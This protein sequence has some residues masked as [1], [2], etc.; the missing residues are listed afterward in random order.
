MQARRVFGDAAVLPNGVCAG[1]HRIEQRQRQRHA[2]PAQHGAPGNVLLGDDHHGLLSH[3]SVH[4]VV[5]HDVWSAPLAPVLRRA[6][7]GTPGSSR[8]P[9]RMRKNDCRC[10]RRIARRWRAPPACRDNPITRPSPYASSF[11]VNVP[12]NASEWFNNGLAQAGRTVEL[13]AVK[14]LARGIDPEAA[15]VGAP[16]AHRVEILQREADRVHHLVAGRAGRDWC[17]A[18]PC[19]R[20]ESRLSACRSSPT[21]LKRRNIRRRR[22]RRRA[23]QHFQHLFA[24]LHRRSPVGH[25]RQRQNAALAQNAEAVRVGHRHAP[26]RGSPATFGIP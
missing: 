15:V 9:A 14:H 13:G 7:S 26:E 17:D 11:S 8:F 10:L 20:T 16:H 24:A 18:P 23:Q 1:H 5:A 4:V 25:R 22:R 3:P 19:A 21:S 6:A 12:M 2:H